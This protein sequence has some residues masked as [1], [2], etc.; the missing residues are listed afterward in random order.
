[1]SRLRLLVAFLVAAA[2]LAACLA[3]CDATPSATAS[4]PAAAPVDT[5]GAVTP[6][7][8]TLPL[9]IP[10]LA[11]MNGAVAQSAGEVFSAATAAAEPDAVTWQRLSAAAVDLVG[12]ATLITLPGTG[13][14]DAAWIADPRWRPLAA[15]MQDAGF[16]VGVAAQSHDRAA[17]TLASSRLAQSCQSCHM[18]FSSRLLTSPPE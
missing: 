8:T 15:D 5:A 1:M 14:E 2:C 6:P 3:A 10:L 16:A 17:L 13:P 11:V 4:P 18:V 7:E 12:N 9:R